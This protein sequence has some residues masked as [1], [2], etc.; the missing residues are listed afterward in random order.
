MS[1][2]QKNASNNESYTSLRDLNEWLCYLEHIHPTEIDLGLTRIKKVAA[3]LFVAPVSIENAASENAA[4]ESAS[5]EV[6]SKEV[7]SEVNVGI[8]FSFAQVITVAGTNGKGTTCAFLE[9][10]LLAEQKTVAVYSSPHI[11]VFNERLRINKK[12]VDDKSLIDAFHLIEKVRGDISLTYY[13]FTTLAAFVVLMKARTDVIILEVGLGG[14]LDATNMIDATIAVITTI[15]LDHQSYLGN[16]RESI[17]YEKAGIMR[18]EGLAVLGDT[19][20][21]NSVINHAKKINADL[22]VRE[23]DFFLSLN[24][25]DWQWSFKHYSLKNLNK[26]HIPKDNV[27]TALTV[28]SLLDVD[29]TTDKVNQIIDGTRV[30]G[31][32]ELFKQQVTLKSELTGQIDSLKIDS[33]TGSEL[34][35]DVMLD[36][37]HNPQ[38]ARYLAGEVA[39]RG[40]SRILA[41]VGMLADKDIANTV[42]PMVEVV[43]EWYLGTLSVPRAATANEIKNALSKVEE[44]VNC[45]DNVTQAFRMAC[46]NADENDLILVFG[47][48]F[49]VS[50]I[51]RLLVI[52]A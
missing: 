27:G 22:H 35:L 36:V 8:D 9:N 40:Y 44:S 23:E 5:S 43:D 2:N 29:L 38:A 50:E 45:F 28:L 24:P 31:R 20:P 41:V 51:R 30:N 19:N 26:P 3:K 13:E 10:A 34:M 47:S 52:P 1:K 33:P 11:E 39:T 49:T 32:T 12:D 7:I 17:G 4:S 37:G 16:D 46:K 18:T 21:P 42:L 25:D 6:V 48:F 15:D 14:R